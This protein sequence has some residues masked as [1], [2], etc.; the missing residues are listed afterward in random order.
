MHRVRP[1]V[2]MMS[3]DWERGRLARIAG[4]TRR[5]NPYRSHRSSTRAMRWLAGWLYQD[6][7]SAMRCNRCHKPMKGTTAYDGACSCG[8]LIEAERAL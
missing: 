7:R 6:E 4:R 1:K 5:D 3:R 2:A 8:G